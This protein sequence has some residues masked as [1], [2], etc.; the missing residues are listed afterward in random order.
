MNTELVAHMQLLGRS[1]GKEFP[2]E[3]SISRPAPSERMAPAWSCTV[4]V[5][6]LWAKSFEIYGDGSFQTLCLSAKHAVQ[7]LATFIE[8]G[9]K[10]M[11][12]DGTDFEPKIFGFRL[13]PKGGARAA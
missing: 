9:G 5:A 12:L 6:P 4:A 1:E 11:H 8:Q 13:L 10:L 7:M 2:V 3:V